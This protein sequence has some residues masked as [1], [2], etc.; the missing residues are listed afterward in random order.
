MAPDISRDLVVGLQS[1]SSTAT[2]GSTISLLPTPILTFIDSTFP[3]IYLPLESCEAFESAF[4]LTWNAT[5]LLYPVNDTLHQ[6]LTARNPNVTFQIGDATT[7]GP[8]VDIVL[9]YASFDLLASY[10]MVLNAT[11]YFPLQRATNESQYTLGRAFLQEAYVFDRMTP[12]KPLGADQCNLRYLITNYENSTFSVSQARFEDGLQE[13][14]IAIPSA[15][16][17]TTTKSHSH[18]SHNSIIGL[19]IGLTALLILIV[20]LVY[21]TRQKLLKHFQKNDTSNNTGSPIFSPEIK[22]ENL[23]ALHEIDNNS[24]LQYRELSDGAALHE[25]DNN[26]LLRFR[27]LPDNG[28]VELLDGTSPSGSGNQISEMPQSPT[29][30]PLCELGTRH[31]SIATSI[32][33]RHSDRTKHGIVVKTG[34]L[35]ESRDSSEPSLKESPHVETVI[36]SSPRHKSQVSDRPL[37]TPP[38]R[39]REYL[40]RAL[41]SI[42]SSDSTDDSPTKTSSSTPESVANYVRSLSSRTSVTDSD[43]D[44]APPE[45][46]LDL[47]MKDYDMSWGSPGRQQ[48]SILSLSSTNIKIMLPPEVAEIPMHEHPSSSSLSTDV[49]I[50]V[51]PATAKPQLRSSP[52]RGQP[53]LRDNFF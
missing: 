11:R 24:L 52:R 51:P 50:L 19:S 33:N 25:A 39:T 29:P 41:P 5:A 16:S 2:N 15:N 20:V 28:K 6:S 53:R 18:L 10:P 3:F 17:T 26:S 22:P 7:G 32:L 35:R 37:R 42:P 21:F 45:S 30:A 44:M 43:S 47:V 31:T 8:T 38:E 9:P 40:N 13:H 1:I 12:L 23:S 46:A 27:E 36:S 48:S 14:I 34:I 4:D 49:D